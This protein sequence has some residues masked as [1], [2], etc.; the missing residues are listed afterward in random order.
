M[1][2]EEAPNLKKNEGSQSFTNLFQLLMYQCFG[3]HYLLL[4]FF[5]PVFAFILVVLILSDLTS[6]GLTLSLT[7]TSVSVE[8]LH[9]EDAGGLQKAGKLALKK[10]TFSKKNFQ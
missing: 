2:E 4:L 10:I 3:N 6:R 1:E 8:A 7:L 5:I 9:A